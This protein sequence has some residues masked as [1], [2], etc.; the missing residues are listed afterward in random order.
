MKNVIEMD[1]MKKKKKIETMLRCIQRHQMVG[2]E[3]FWAWNNRERERKKNTSNSSNRNLKL[4]VYFFLIDF[5][6]RFY[7]NDRM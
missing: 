2:T 1:K 5:Q 6:V 3:Y 4:Q 7:A